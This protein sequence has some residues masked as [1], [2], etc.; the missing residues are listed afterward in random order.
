MGE[1]HSSLS[2]S[3][4]AR[5]MTSSPSPRED[6]PFALAEPKHDFKAHASARCQT[7]YLFSS[8]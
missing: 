2:N 6:E 1:Q 7:C 5:E 8:L 3:L 4:Q